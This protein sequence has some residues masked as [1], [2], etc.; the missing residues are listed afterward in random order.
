MWPHLFRETVGGKI[1]INE[2]NLSGLFKVMSRLDLEN[3]ETA[4]HYVKRWAGDIIERSNFFI[5]LV[6]VFGVKKLGCLDRLLRFLMSK[7]FLHYIV[8]PFITY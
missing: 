4:Q 1:V 2:N 5:N 6:G 3:L 8:L 7:A